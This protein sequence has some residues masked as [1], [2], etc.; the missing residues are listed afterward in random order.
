MHTKQV[1][2]ATRAILGGGGGWRGVEEG[3]EGRK[4]GKGG[5]GKFYKWERR[6]EGV[7]GESRSCRLPGWV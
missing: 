1:I 3:V 2:Q 6:G 4:K 5:W 7:A